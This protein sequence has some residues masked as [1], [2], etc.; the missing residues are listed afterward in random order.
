MRFTN[1]R[2][3]RRLS[4][5]LLL[6]S[7][8]ATTGAAA[9]CASESDPAVTDAPIDAGQ[10]ASDGAADESATDSSAPT[11]HDASR[12][13]AGPTAVT[14]GSDKCVISLVTVG[15]GEGF[16]AH[17]HDDTV[18]CWGEN[19]KGQLGR[20]DEAN[21][22]GDGTPTRVVGLSNVVDL[23]H[24]CAVDKSGDT[25]CWGTGSFLR[26]ETQPVT[27]EKAP[28]KLPLP[29]ATKVM[30]ES[31][32]DHGVGCVVTEAGLSCW[33]S[34]LYGVLG[35]PAFGDDLYAPQP[36]RPVAMPNSTPIRALALGHAAFA[37]HDDGTLTSWGANPPLGRV[38]SLFPDPKPKPIALSGVKDVDVQGDNACAAA[39]GTAYCWGTPP[40]DPYAGSVQPLGRALPEPVPTPEPVVQVATATSTSYVDPRRGCAVSDKGT[41][42][43]WGDNANGQVGDGTKNYATSVVKVALP[44]P[45]AQ[46]KT[47]TRTTCAVL[48]SGKVMCWGDDRFG[49]L[50][51]GTLRKPSLIPQEVVLP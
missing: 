24:T 48:L 9:S 17:Y 13:D 2:P 29:P 50:G 51:A 6:L 47:T 39:E 10:G 22:Y 7:L 1:R 41:V 31:S 15:D 43:C 49:Q 42:Y 33:G 11:P 4:G 21:N 27:T 19:T 46:V 18:V 30:V 5:A 32:Y 44:E 26:D 12:S 3:D 35:Q 34:N 25:W 38:S 8:G 45:A 40:G 28:V 23:D 36:P 37:L 20:G 16:C 14:C